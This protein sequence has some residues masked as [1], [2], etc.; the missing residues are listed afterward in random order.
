MSSHVIPCESLSS[1][2]MRKRKRGAEYGSY[3]DE[4]TG[5]VTTVQTSKQAKRAHQKSGKWYKEPTEA[6]L[7]AWDREEKRQ[8]LAD[9]AAKK[10]EN[11][12]LNAVKRAEKERKDEE[13]KRRMFQAGKITFTQTLAKKDEDQKNLHS[14]FG[15]RPGASKVSK[16][17][18]DSTE[19]V[20][21]QNKESQYKDKDDDATVIVH[22]PGFNQ[23]PEK[24]LEQV[25]KLSQETVND[26]MDAIDDEIDIEEIFDNVVISPVNKNQINRPHHHTETNTMDQTVDRPIDQDTSPDFEI[27]EDDSAEVVAPDRDPDPTTVNPFKV[28]ALPSHAQVVSPTRLPLSPMS[29]SDINIRNFQTTMQVSSFQSRLEKAKIETTPSTQVVRD[30]LSGICTQDL[31]DDIEDL[32]KE[33]DEPEFDTP[34]SI[35]ASPIKSVKHSS[36]LKNVS[37]STKVDVATSPVL[38]KSFNSFADSI[39][40]DA[41]FLDIDNPEKAENGFDHDHDT[42]DDEDFDDEDFDDCGLDDATL[43]SLPSATQLIPST[44]N[45]TPLA[46]TLG[47]APMPTTTKSSRQP[48]TKT[49]SFA[50]ALEG[51]DDDDLLAG[52]NEYERSQNLNKN[53]NNSTPT[54]TANTSK[55]STSKSSHKKKR[56]LPWERQDWTA[57]AGAVDLEAAVDVTEDGDGDTEMTGTQDTEVLSSF[58]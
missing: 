16:P 4:D 11:K 7:R 33:N 57:N 45:S 56:I 36:P 18:A 34:A 52:L 5:E 55:L 35:A 40:Y 58:G 21:E 8:A 9:R 39:D 1:T 2:K 30:I 6:E 37:F 19:N 43:L 32:D 29:P 51:L 23:D 38:N 26:L 12:K 42:F 15:G 25:K 46:S 28:P 22:D 3:V 20:K 50:L 54:L 17:V 14:W 10:E 48:L 44:R 49:D 31:T 53:Q 27:L 13:L 41:M 24:C 47:P